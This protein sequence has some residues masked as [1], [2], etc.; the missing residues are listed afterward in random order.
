MLSLHQKQAISQISF[1]R[2]VPD[3]KIHSYDI[4]RKIAVY[5]EFP[6]AIHMISWEK[7]QVSSNPLKAARIAANKYMT[8]KA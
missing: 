1:N 6:Q 3:S 4:G 8:K 7:E 5:N 2:G